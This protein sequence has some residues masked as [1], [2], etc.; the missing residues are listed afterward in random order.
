MSN[1]VLVEVT[2]GALIESRHRGAVAVADA[3]GRS[4]LA[5]GDVAAPV[6]PRSAIKALQAMALVEEGA[7]DRFGFDDEALALACAS[8]SGEPA[9]VAGVE[10]ILAK[11]GLDASALR[12]GVHWPISQSA[13]YALARTGTASALH[14][15]CSGKHAG[16]LCLACAKGADTT[17]YFRP[18]HPVQRQV[19]AVLEDFT[20]AVLGEAVCGIDGC[21]V[22]TWAVPLQNL[23]HGFA[24]FGTGR[25][26]SPAR[27]AAAGRL[28]QACAAKPWF[29]A[30]SGRFCTEIMQLFGDRVFVKTGAEGVYCATLPQQGLGIALKCDDGAARAAQAVVA[31]VIARFLPLD[32]AQRA[33]LEP[34]MQPSLRNW[35]GFEVGAIKVTAA[36]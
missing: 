19:R 31:T 17:G 3:E 7:A 30:G 23:A 12:C 28:R 22:P 8:H 25:G 1:P 14:N 24:K 16:F 32:D 26:L 33:A 9:H 6:V 4:V 34:L 10:R 29:V 35:N 20:G 11:A 13:A 18:E 2:R 21:S 15:N 36:I 5:I 27:A